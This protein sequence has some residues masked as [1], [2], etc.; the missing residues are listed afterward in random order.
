MF[1]RFTEKARRVIFFA[2]YYARISEA[3][4][5]GTEHL[6]LGIVREDGNSPRGIFGREFREEIRKRFEPVVSSGRN[7]LVRDLPLTED[8]KQAIALAIG[9][10][11]R[12]HEAGVGVEEL[13]IGIL[14]VQNCPLIIS[15][16]K[17]VSTLRISAREWRNSIFNNKKHASRR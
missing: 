8:S 17:M 14:R 7:L 10:A 9:E 15:S 12:L 11:D 4:M 6:L 16:L 5:I 1:E 13:C 3:P 2:G